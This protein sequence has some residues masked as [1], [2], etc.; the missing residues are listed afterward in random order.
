MKL[1]KII[2]PF[3]VAGL[4][5]GMALPALASP[6][7]AAAQPATVAFQPDKDK[8]KRPEKINT[9]RGEVKAISG[10][11]ITVNDKSV[12]T[13]NATRFKVPGLGR[14]ATLADIAVGMQVT[15]L[16][17]Q[18]DSQLYARQV[19]VTPGKPGAKHHVGTVTA[20][21]YDTA[22]GGNITIETK[23]NETTTFAI[24]AGKFKILPA[25]A[26]VKVGD[27]VT[28]ISSRDTTQN[29]LIASGVVVHTVKPRP[30]PMKQVRGTITAIDETAKT[31][32]IGTTVLTY[33]DQT[34]FELRGFPAVKTGQQAIAHYSKVDTTLVAKKVLVGT[35]LPQLQSEPEELE[36]T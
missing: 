10:S 8:G 24:L 4:V 12:V 1:F 31:V 35:N 11:V 21:A 15:A 23:K 18:K 13:D 29:R 14:D 26:A 28:V 2:V 34:I 9:V 19:M 25:G 3:L 7:A 33:N 17:Q 32:T 20:Y 5:L 6:G 36:Q 27:N 22:A 16:V 30:N